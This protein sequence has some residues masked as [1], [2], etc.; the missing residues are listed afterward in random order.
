MEWILE[1]SEEKEEKERD[2]PYDMGNGAEK[3]TRWVKE[4]RSRVLRVGLDWIC[5]WK[6][7]RENGGR[8]MNGVRKW[9]KIEN[10]LKYRT[11]YYIV[12]QNYKTERN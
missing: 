8:R 9:H 5:S 12:R 4:E 7:Q 10:N 1:G 2:L 3:G 6:E 11:Y